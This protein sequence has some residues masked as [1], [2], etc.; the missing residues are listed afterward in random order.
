MKDSWNITFCFLIYESCGCIVVH[1]F[2]ESSLCYYDAFYYYLPM[3]G[4][5][6]NPLWFFLF[7]GITDDDLRE[8][9]YEVLLA[10]AGASG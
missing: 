9:A 3:E 6:I 1:L 7:T 10:C 2:E 8:T 5:I 4:E